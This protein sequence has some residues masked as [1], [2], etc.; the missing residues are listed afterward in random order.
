MAGFAKAPFLWLCLTELL[1]HQPPGLENGMVGDF[2]ERS[3]F[4]YGKIHSVWTLNA[5]PPFPSETQICSL[6]H[7]LPN[8]TDQHWLTTSSE[9]VGH[10][11]VC[12]ML[13]R[14]SSPRTVSHPAVFTAANFFLPKMEANLCRQTH[15]WCKHTE[16]KSSI[17][18]SVPSSGK[19]SHGCF[20]LLLSVSLI[21]VQKVSK[22]LMTAAFPI[23]AC[24]MTF[25]YW[26]QMN[27]WKQFD[28]ATFRCFWSLPKRPQK[29]P[30][31]YQKANTSI[32]SD[33]NHFSFKNN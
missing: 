1:K 13:P 10:A 16:A 11:M 7:W 12:A 24:C 23:A 20:Y 4:Q 14:K 5:A 19:E 26:K 18:K 2:W 17:S 6:L 27:N 28:H 9:G 25:R 21:G 33:I 32:N 31:S 29:T 3:G 22:F 30:C 8:L 15:A